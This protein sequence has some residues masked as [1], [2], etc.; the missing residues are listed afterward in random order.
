ANFRRSFKRWTG[1]TPNLIRQL[2]SS[3]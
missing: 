2:F 1:S 3:R